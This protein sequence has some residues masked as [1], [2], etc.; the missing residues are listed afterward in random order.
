[1]EGKRTSGNCRFF[2]FAEPQGK[3]I[4]YGFD[5]VCIIEKPVLPTKSKCSP[6]V[7][8]KFVNEKECLGNKRK[9]NLTNEELIEVSNKIT[10][11]MMRELGDEVQTVN[12]ADMICVLGIIHRTLFANIEA[13]DGIEKARELT[14][15]LVG[16]IEATLET[17]AWDEENKCMK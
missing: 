17:G 6:C 5:G 3:E 15:F 8:H 11:E 1:M 7:D 12:P 14:G 9:K 4:D 10:M 2:K 13:K 16:L